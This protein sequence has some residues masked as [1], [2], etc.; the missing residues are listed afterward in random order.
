MQ[1]INSSFNNNYNGYSNSY[2]FINFNTK[3]KKKYK[4]NLILEQSY[5]YLEIY[6]I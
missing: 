1:K 2:S 3:S 5:S 6:L 4:K